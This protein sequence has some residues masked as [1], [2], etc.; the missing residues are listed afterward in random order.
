MPWLL[1]D[2]AVL[3][4]L[5]QAEGRAERRRGLLGRT[6]IEG[7][8]WLARTRSVHTLGMRFPIDVAHVDA[9]GTV[10]RTRTMVPGRIGRPVRRATAVLEAEA[11]AFARWG[12]AVGSVVEVVERRPE[13]DG[14]DR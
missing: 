8:I 7:A 6:G 9:S 12:L 10:V 4:S 2:G 14:T 3:A 1:S 13:R 11:G 5:E